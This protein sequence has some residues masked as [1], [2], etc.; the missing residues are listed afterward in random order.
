M[1]IAVIGK[2]TAGTIAAAY[3]KDKIKG[4]EVNLY[5]T[6]KIQTIGVGE[7]GGPRLKKFLEN[8]NIDETKFI[9][10]TSA[11]KKWGILF[12]NWGNNSKNTVHHF[13]PVRQN[14]SYH[15]DASKF[16][17][18]LIQE[19]DLTINDF[20][21]KSIKYLEGNGKVKIAFEETYSIY[22]YVVNASGF[23]KKEQSRSFTGEKK[24]LL[25]CNEAL[26]MQTENTDNIIK[27]YS[28]EGSKYNSLTL[29]KAMKHGW[30][31]SIPLQNRTSYGYIYSSEYSNT[32]EIKDEMLALINKIETKPKYIAERKIQFKTFSRGQFCNHRIF[33]I[34]NR[35]AFAEPLEA[36]AI[37]FILRE[38]EEIE[39]YLKN[40]NEYNGKTENEKQNIFNSKL[41]KE[42][43]RIALFIGWH[44]SNGSIHKSTFWSK[45]KSHYSE[46]RE[47]II[48]SSIKDEFDKW[49]LNVNY[50]GPKPETPFFGWSFN[51][52]QE[53]L[54]AIN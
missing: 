44:Y 41:D 13:T 3:L 30:L 42:M 33:E 19:K 46:M 21:V 4:A 8:M 2:G 47:K 36:T 1:K 27:E 6:D 28:C 51:S 11:T 54:K 14:Y 18:L 40:H 49:L 16:Q 25:L 23:E 32:D 12:E 43:E 38:C 50:I 22:D 52:F 24:Q 15:F 20:E 7:G 39:D 48:S 35:A 53:V 45:A 9:G 5:Y 26:L 10:Y 31:F 29:S 37:E 17:E 34:G